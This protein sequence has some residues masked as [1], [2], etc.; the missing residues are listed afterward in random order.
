MNKS[1]DTRAATRSGEDGPNRA[2]LFGG[3]LVVVVVAALV[4]AM[5]FSGGDGDDND[6][7]VAATGDEASEAPETPEPA[8]TPDAGE[9][10]PDQSPG[11]TGQVQLFGDPLPPYDRTAPTDVAVGKPAPGFVAADF[12][13]VEHTVEPGDGSAKVIGFFAHWCGHCQREL[14]RL[15]D[16]LDNNDAPDGVEIIGV[17]TAVD[18]GQPNY[19]PSDW[20]E[21]EGW[22]PLAVRD[23]AESELAIGYG[24]AG[25]PYFV[26]VGS[27]GNVVIRVS[28]ELTVAQW[29]A[30]LDLADESA[31]S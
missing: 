6:D 11:E 17:S 12:G 31:T 21:T 10:D 25:F 20:F 14:P 29:E 2:L 3:G 19:P 4:A 23:S 1:Q 27:D 26:V 30:L 7:S 15:V 13:G 18:A 22:T 28:G 9:T 5:L 8:E 16:W 24:L